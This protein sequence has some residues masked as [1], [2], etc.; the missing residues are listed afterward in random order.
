VDVGN[1]SRRERGCAGVARANSR[2]L[3]KIQPGLKPQDFIDNLVKRAGILESAGDEGYAFRH[4]S[5][6]EFLAAG[7]LAEEV[8]RTPDRAQILVNNFNEGRW[9]E[10]LLFALGLH[11]PVIFTDFMSRFL[12][13]ENN[14]GGFPVLLG[15][16][17]FAIRSSWTRSTFALKAAR[18]NSL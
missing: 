6:R 17:V 7:Q 15:Q 10:T 14:E 12:P 8:Q 4:K 5:F 3:G 2:T 13:H 11:K 18:T 16:R 1:S 9:H